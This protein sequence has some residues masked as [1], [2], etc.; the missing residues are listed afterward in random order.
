MNDP[1]DRAW[2]VTLTSE[3]LQLRSIDEADRPWLVALQ[4]NA[5]ARD[6]LGGPRSRDASEAIVAKRLSLGW[7]KFVVVERTRGQC[8]GEVDFGDDRGE[9]E[10][11]YVFHPNYWGHGFAVDALSVALPWA[12]LGSETESVIAVT[13]AANTRS[14]R[15]LD[16][17][18]FVERERF[19]EFCEPQVLLRW[20]HK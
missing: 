7:G 2:P 4:M 3:H 6:R 16:R 12:A 10:V 13:Q 15:L 18:G 9:M 5:V 17:L 1:A 8:I 11:S 19:V 20:F 14:L